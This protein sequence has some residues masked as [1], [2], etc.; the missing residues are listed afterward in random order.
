MIDI[1]I[2]S[3]IL[4][5]A[6]ILLVTEKL[7]VDVTAIGVMVL[8]AL[9]G[10]LDPLAAVS[11]FANPAVITVAAMFFISSAMVRTGAVSF[12]GDRV[13]SVSKG[14]PVV[15]LSLVFLIVAVSSAF[16]N[17]TPVVVLFIPVLMSMGCE[18]GF[19][20]SRL[21][22]PLS[23]VSILAGTCTLLGTS[24]NII[25]SDLSAGFGYGDIGMFELAK[26]GLPIALVGIAFIF[27]AAKKLLPD[28]ANPTCELE[29]SENR[30]YLSQFEI[31]GKSPLQGSR[32]V[33]RF[34]DPYPDLEIVELVRQGHIFYPGRDAVTMAKGD[35][36]LA[37]GT[38]SDLVAIIREN[39]GQLPTEKDAPPGES[40]G[41]SERMLV[42]VIIPPQ[43]SLLGEQLRNVNLFKSSGIQIIAAQRKGFQYTEKKIGDI[44]LKVGDILLVQ[45]PWQKLDQLRGLADFIVV[46]DVH[47]RMTNRKKAPLAGLIFLGVVS[48]A[49]TGLL[50]IMTST[51]TGVFLL[52]I[53]RCIGIRD[54]YRAIQG[55]VL[56]LIAGTIALGI[57]ME[58]TGTSRL[59]AQG[60][61]ELFDGFPPIVIL[62]AFI[63]F[64]SISTQL[65]SNNAT[66][67]LILPIAISTALTI[68]VSPRPFIIGVCIGASA[69][70]A[71]P[72][73]YQTN[74]LVY[75]PGGYRFA[76]FFKI[77]V[78]LNLMVLVIG[79]LLIPVFWPF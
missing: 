36:L 23:F 71:T 48:T 59:Y 74:L 21:L 66:A 44:R 58:K 57:A 73:G 38:A 54:A 56:V 13:V 7:P 12:L 34:R 20:P 9:T 69:C 51:L 64:T 72:I 3:L 10:I 55:N 41:P 79:T 28:T 35:L 68:G 62:G 43:S 31:T 18:Y 25:V 26:V 4:A 6:V 16:I 60:F 77:G 50:D 11:G 17:N 30:K 52:S 22:I 76:D 70:F 63:L 33:R 78:P 65:L 61:L 40:P 37:K 5:G 46:E 24:T 67:I 47:H 15:A 53:T 1:W 75:G 27:P 45:L 2:V 49:A 39:E 19:S 32:L 8:L 29:N 42:E 14:N